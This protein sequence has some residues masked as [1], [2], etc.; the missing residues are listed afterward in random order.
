MRAIVTDCYEERNQ[1]IFAEGIKKLNDAGIK[2][3]GK[4]FIN[5]KAEEKHILL[6]YLD[7]KAKDY[8]AKKKPEAPA[9][10]FRMMKELTVWGY[11]SSEAG[12]Y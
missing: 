5:L 7:K 2:K 10:Y 11:F 1:K 6:V 8:H 4:D 3:F 12:A 9:H